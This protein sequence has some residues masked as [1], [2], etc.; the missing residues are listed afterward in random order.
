MKV[1]NFRAQR[2]VTP[3]TRQFY[4]IALIQVVVV[5]FFPPPHSRVAKKIESELNNCPT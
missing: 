3:Q 2:S 4:A 5:V 1:G